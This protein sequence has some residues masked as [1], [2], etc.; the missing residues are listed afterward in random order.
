MYNTSNRNNYW[1]S[2][3]QLHGRWKIQPPPPPPPP[4]NLI[5]WKQE[6]AWDRAR[7]N[8]RARLQLRRPQG[9]GGTNQEHNVQGDRTDPERASGKH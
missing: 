7:G 9:R 5:V 1:D 2:I 6:T 3:H 4:H 8:W